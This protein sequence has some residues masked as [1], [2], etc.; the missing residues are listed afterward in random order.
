VILAVDDES[1][2]LGRL[3]HELRKRYEADYRVVCE[4]SAEAGLQKLRELK[5]AEANLAIVIAAQ[6]M[7][8]IKG[9]EFLARVREAYPLAKRLLLSNPMDRETTDLLPRAMTL[10]CIDFFEFKQGPPPT[11]VSTWSLRTFSRSGLS[12]IAPRF[13]P[14]YAWWG[15]GGPEGCT[16]PVLSSNATGCLTRS[17]R[18][19]RRRARLSS[20]RSGRAQSGQL[21]TRM[22]QNYH[23]VDQCVSS[24]RRASELLISS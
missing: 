19:T 5:V 1:E 22:A 11:S 4:A 6:R 18:W 17:T 21:S 20:R 9:V 10:G 7:P 14:W 13:K 8:R 24:R 15:S 16:K 2:D 23:E 12:L 3:E